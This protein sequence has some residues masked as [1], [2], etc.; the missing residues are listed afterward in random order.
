MKR[1]VI[2]GIVIAMMM[3]V[4]ACGSNDTFKLKETTYTVELGQDISTEAKTYLMKDTR[5]DVLKNTSIIFEKDK[6]FT[7]DRQRNILKPTS[8]MY[9][10]VGQYKATATYEKESKKFTVEIKDTT[11]PKFVDFKK[12]ITIVQGSEVDLSSYFKAEDFSKVTIAI[13]GKF[14]ANIVGTYDISVTAKDE[15]KNK[16]MKKAILKVVSKEDAEKEGISTPTGKGNSSSN[17]E[18]TGG[19]TSG[20]NDYVSSGNNANNGNAGYSG[21]TTTPTPPP[22][23]V[24]VPDLTFQGQLGNSGRW[25]YSKEEAYAWAWEQLE[26]DGYW[27]N[28]GYNGFHAWT[29][30]DNCMNDY[31]TWWTID[32]Y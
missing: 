22:S 29:L 31:P 3:T 20:G 13:D 10:P 15:Y 4:T 32:F 11:A 8:G 24:C 18:S 27:W 14:D 12:E 2:T 25:F 1:T 21:G 6:R 17:S 9:L 19:S 23:N 28:Q 30:I 26:S 7:V 16:V 5:E